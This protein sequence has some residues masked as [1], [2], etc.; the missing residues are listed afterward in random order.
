[1][2][3]EDVPDRYLPCFR[4]TSWKH[5]W[6]AVCWHDFGMYRFAYA[7]GT[8]TERS[9]MISTILLTEF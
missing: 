7:S 8:L 3:R 2:G 4:G 9:Y 6:R 1:M 5:L